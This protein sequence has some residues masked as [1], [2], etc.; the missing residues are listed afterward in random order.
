M[1]VRSSDHLFR[2]HSQ[3]SRTSRMDGLDSCCV[4]R[5][6]RRHPSDSVGTYLHTPPTRI[7]TY[8]LNARRRDQN[9]RKKLF[10]KKKNYHS[11]FKVSVKDKLKNRLSRKKQI[12]PR[13]RENRELEK[14][15]LKLIVITIVVK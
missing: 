6:L 13:N 8:I 7:I 5:L 4:R 12:F 9:P 1:Y 10:L 2:R 15:Y 14:N 3:Q 11:R